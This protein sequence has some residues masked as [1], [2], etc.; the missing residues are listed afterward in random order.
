[1]R[2]TA[3]SQLKEHEAQSARD[4]EAKRALDASLDIAPTEPNAK[5]RPRQFSD[6]SQASVKHNPLQL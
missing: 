1:M 6:W 3:S 4:V 5:K 2:A